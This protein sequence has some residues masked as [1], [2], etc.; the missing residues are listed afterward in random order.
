MFYHQEEAA[1]GFPICPPRQSQGAKEGSKNLF[2]HHPGRVA[3]S[4]PLVHG[5]GWSK[6]GKK[7]DDLPLPPT[8]ADLAT[9]SGLVAARTSL[10]EDRPEKPAPSKLDP[11]NQISRFPGSVNES[12]KQDWKNH[13][14]LNEDSHRLEDGMGS[15][16]EPI[17]VR[18]MT[19]CYG[20]FFFF[21]RKHDLLYDS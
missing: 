1:S 2:E 11:R 16:K 15:T 8:R 5:A 12:G 19:N 9:L 3:F 6:A 17:L 20:S 7:H 14:Q 21:F 4:G 18:S 10:S 13:N